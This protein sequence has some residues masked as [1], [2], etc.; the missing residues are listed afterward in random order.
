ME[1]Y[2]IDVMPVN[3]GCSSDISP[4][5][6][7]AAEG[8]IY[9][10]S[11]MRS[12]R[13]SGN[14]NGKVKIGGEL[15]IYDTYTSINSATFYMSGY[16]CIGFTNCKNYLVGFWSDNTTTRVTMDD[17]IVCESAN[18]GLTTDH[19]LQIDVNESC[20]GGEVFT[21]DNNVVPMIWSLK[22]LLDNWTANSTLYFSQFNLS[23]VSI[24]LDTQNDKPFFVSLDD[25]VGAGLGVM[26][27]TFAYAMRYVDVDGN[28]T[29]HSAFTP[30]IPVINSMEIASNQYP[31]TRIIGGVTGFSSNYGI[32]LNYRVTNVNNY[33]YVEFIRLKF[34][35]GSPLG[36]QPTVETYKVSN[37]LAEG[38]ISVETFIDKKALDTDWL[39]MTPEEATIVIASVQS[40]K[41]V[42][43]FEN[44]LELGNIKYNSKALEPDDILLYQTQQTASMFTRIFK[45]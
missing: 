17:K 15:L 43:Y 39:I 8:Q 5:L 28:K 21:T 3:G 7:N 11:N 16:E 45:T 20:V 32:I 34:I 38:Q 4:E 2:K 36:T 27:G 35:E 33:S 14:G 9:D 1:Q 18:V 26:R 30:I 12:G 24:S 23:L 13:E 29:K 22:V 31:N 42:R 19:P 40:A 41:S 10:A 25:T 44:R 6:I 37:P